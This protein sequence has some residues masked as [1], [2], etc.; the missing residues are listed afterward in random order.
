MIVLPFVV[1]A[2]GAPP[3]FNEAAANRGESS[4]EGFI[5]VSMGSMK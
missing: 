2:V 4:S 1:I 3:D 5:F